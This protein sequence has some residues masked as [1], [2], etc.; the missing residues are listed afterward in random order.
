MR[1]ILL[2][3]FLSFFAT[4]K[5]PESGTVFLYKETIRD[6]ALLL[7]CIKVESNGNPD[8]VN[9]AENALGLLQIREVMLT[10]VNRI[11]TLQNVNK[12]YTR[13]DCLD[14]LKSIEMFY[15]VQDFH[16]PTGDIFRGCEVWN[17]KS[18]YHKYYSKVKKLI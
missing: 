4:L 17:G 6:K 8:A 2:I 16:N 11:L 15:I 12:H 18:K 9:W 1:T 3:L 10:E 13:A 7:A 5:A 14:S